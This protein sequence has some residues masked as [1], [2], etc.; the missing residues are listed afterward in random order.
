MGCCP[1]VASAKKKPEDSPEVVV[2]KEIFDVILNPATADA[3]TSTDEPDEPDEPK[4]DEEEDETKGGDMTGYAV[5]RPQLV[6]P[7]DSPW[8]V[9]D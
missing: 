1:S 3:S 5:R 2:P 6:S 7:G 8:A 4:E 9:V